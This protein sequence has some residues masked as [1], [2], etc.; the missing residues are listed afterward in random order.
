MTFIS[1]P[2][3]V[4]F[5]YH[6]QKHILLLYYHDKGFG[7]SYDEWKFEEEVSVQRI[8][9][10]DKLCRLE[11]PIGPSAPAAPPLPRAPEPSA[12][13]KLTPTQRSQVQHQSR[14]ERVAQCQK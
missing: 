9:A 6:G 14:D 4:D 5:S 13:S 10:H 8:K 2:L 12:P 1:G 11:C 3:R 7:P